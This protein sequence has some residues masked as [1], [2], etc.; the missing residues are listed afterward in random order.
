MIRLWLGASIGRFLVGWL[1]VCLLICQQMLDFVDVYMP[2]TK[3]YEE[4]LGEFRN[5]VEDDV[6]KVKV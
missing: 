5:E 2:F 3:I 1:S 6:N 4:L